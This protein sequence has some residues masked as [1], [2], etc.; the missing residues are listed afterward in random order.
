MYMLNSPRI[1]GSPWR[2]PTCDERDTN[3]T[4]RDWLVFN[5]QTPKRALPCTLYMHGGESEFYMVWN[6]RM[7]GAPMRSTSTFRPEKIALLLE[8]AG[9]VRRDQVIVVGIY[10]PSPAREPFQ[11]WTISYL[12]R[13][14]RQALTD[15]RNQPRHN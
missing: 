10:L 2:R 15:W 14:E 9:S 6:S 13:G 12:I 4:L 5:T 3:S 8:K 7:V 1:V 11:F